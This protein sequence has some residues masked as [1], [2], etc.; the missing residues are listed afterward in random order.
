MNSI[1]ELVSYGIR[2]ENV[3][4]MIESYQKLVGTV[5]GDYEI[6]DISYNPIAK[7]RMVKLRCT[8]CGDE[9]QREI[10]KGRN[11]WSELIKTCSKCR[12]KRRNAE[13]EKN[14]KIKKDLLESEIGK[15]YGDYIATEIISYNPIKIRMV[16]GECGAIKDVSYSMLHTGKWKD[17]K[18]HKHFSNIKY[19]ESYIGKRFGFLTVIGINKP[20]EVRRFM[21][22]CDCG[23]IKNVRPNELVSGTIKSCGCYHDESARTHGGSSDRLYH[24]WQ[25]MKKRCN[26]PKCREYSNYGGRGIRV[27]NEWN[28]YSTFKRWA[29]E[30]GYDED[31]PFGE[32]T[33]DRIDVNGNYEPDN[34]RWIT[35]LE[36]QKNKRPPSEWKKR[37]NKKKT[38]LIL[39][40]G[41]LMPKS[42]LCKSHGISVET[43]N[44]RYH[45]KGMSIQ[46]ALETPKMVIGR[47]R[48]QDINS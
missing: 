12:E 9:I 19:D 26:Y 42:D 32:C 20:G 2:K 40:N 37:T 48:K 13:L 31:A 11:K 44:Y 34:C 14:E 41:N 28:D 4:R 7:A 33:I 21:C 10:V 23:N 16:C 25:D 30:H 18:C 15:Q 38:A 45:K 39:Y 36:Q 1:E 29:C 46:K 47:P 3:S 17:Q 5:N 27:C 24:V 35:I 43:F 6:I 22:R 8:T